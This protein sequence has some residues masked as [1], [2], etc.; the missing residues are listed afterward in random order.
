MKPKIT[1]IADLDQD[2]DDIIAIEYLLK[3]DVLSYIVCDPNPITEEGKQR[4]NKLILKGAVKFPKIQLGTKIVFC[5]GALTK[6]AEFLEAGNTLDTLVMNGG[7]VGNNIIVAKEQLPKFKYKE[8]VRTYNFNMD[9]ESTKKVLSMPENKLGEIILVG[10]HL[11]HDEKNTIKGLW[12]SKFFKELQ[13]EYKFNSDK[14]LHDVLACHEGLSLLNIIPDGT[15]CDYMKL[16]PMNKED[17]W[18]SAINNKLWKK[19]GATLYRK[20]QVAVYYK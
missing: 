3:Y 16:Y 13:E 14:R 10:K 6:V 7:F 15:Y 20:C 2:I 1:Y 19:N 12:S 11:C 9:I 5:G 4:L 17:T 8:F 18:G